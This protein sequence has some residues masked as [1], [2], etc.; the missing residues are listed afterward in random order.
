MYPVVGSISNSPVVANGVVYVGSEDHSL[1]ALDAQSG[2]LLWSYKTGNYILT[3]PA[4]VN[5]VVYIGSGDGRL[6]AFHLPG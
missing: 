6:Y 5:G 2:K 4:V 3:S 1:Y